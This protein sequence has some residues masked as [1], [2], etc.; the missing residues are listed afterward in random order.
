MKR[1]LV[2]LVTIGLVRAGACTCVPGPSAEEAFREAKAVFIGRVVKLEI[3][4]SRRF[5]GDDGIECVL[6]VFEAFKGEALAAGPKERRVFVV[7]TGNGGGDCGFPFT[8]GALYLV[9]ASGDG[10]L[11]TDI[12]TRTKESRKA[13]GTELRAL[14]SLAAKK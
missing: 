3:L 4:P 10:V 1:L 13:E 2:I 8:L 6:E 7:R 9:Y 11:E 5:M 14:R 12:C